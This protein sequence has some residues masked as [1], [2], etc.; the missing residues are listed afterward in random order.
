MTRRAKRRP[1]PTQPTMFQITRMP[2]CACVDQRHLELVR[3]QLSCAV[4]TFE[5]LPTGGVARHQLQKAFLKPDG[6]Q[7]RLPQGLVSLL[8]TKLRLLGHTVVTTSRRLRLA[9]LET[10]HRILDTVPPHFRSLL[11]KMSQE[12]MGQILIQRPSEVPDL[13][14]AIGA[15]WPQARIIVG[16]K[17]RAD[18]RRLR[19]LVEPLTVRPV[20]DEPWA[21]VSVRRYP[22]EAIRIV[23]GLE[24]EC[25]NSTYADI[26]IYADSESALKYARSTDGW[27]G[28]DI[29]KFAALP[30]SLR[31][32]E[33]ELME[34]HAAFGARILHFGLLRQGL[35]R[36]TAIPVAFR[37]Q[38]SG[39]T[40]VNLS[41]KRSRIWSNLER[42]AALKTLAL[43]L[44]P[45]TCKRPAAPLGRPF[46][47]LALPEQVR[48]KAR[49]LLGRCGSLAIVVES[50]EHGRALQALLPEAELLSRESSPADSERA[51]SI[52][53][54]HDVQKHRL[55][56]SVV[57]RAD[58]IGPWPLAGPTFRSASSRP[59]RLIIDVV[60]CGPNGPLR[61]TD[62][63]ARLSHYASMGWGLEI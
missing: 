52:C 19:K 42:N 16:L 26:L 44:M 21:H 60:D 5:Q 55:S 33:R 2:E 27:L 51:L 8:E 45:T 32:S 9:R 1:R 48:D 62:F 7:V 46:R 10:D 43:Q 17:S 22:S 59:E 29:M 18:A 41:E 28:G 36:V 6:D 12:A 39:A 35:S 4:N 58:G 56:A 31:L 13:V 50:L 54:M 14:A 20:S 37:C 30:E 25:A 23:A 57:I 15:Y 34:L 49:A 53:T 47:G 38:S 3:R 40:P 61:W 24:A 63:P 11:A